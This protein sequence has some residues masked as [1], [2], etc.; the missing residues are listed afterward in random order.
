[1][2][3]RTR[4]AIAVVALL[5][6][7]GGHELR[8]RAKRRAEAAER[9]WLRTERDSY[10]TAAWDH[11][12]HHRREAAT[13]ALRA[14]ALDHQLREPPAADRLA[15][16]RAAYATRS[17]AEAAGA[18]ALVTVLAHVPGPLPAR[19]TSDGDFAIA[20]AHG[21]TTH[22]GKTGKLLHSFGGDTSSG[23]A[24]FQRERVLVARP[25]GDLVAWNANTEASIGEN[26]GLATSP[27]DVTFARDAPFAIA[28]RGG[29]CTVVDGDL[30]ERTKVVPPNGI[31]AT[32][33]APDG[34][35]VAIAGQDGGWTVF[36]VDAKKAVVTISSVASPPR[37]FLTNEAIVVALAET[38]VL[39]EVS[40]KKVAELPGTV[41][42]VSD[43]GAW[44]ATESRGQL[45]YFRTI[46]GGRRGGFELG[47]RQRT[48]LARDGRQVAVL[49]ETRPDLVVRETTGREIATFTGHA[50]P[51]TA[52]SW[53]GDGRYL[54]TASQDRTLRLW[55]VHADEHAVAEIEVDEVPDEIHL[56]RDATRIVTSGRVVRLYDVSIDG[57]IA[58]LCRAAEPEPAVEKVCR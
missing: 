8:A 35:H 20:G 43:D 30:R 49:D 29:D 46:T 32:L 13:M 5:A 15:I 3:R 37:A 24:S 14:V 6:V 11:A 34:K 23:V 18:P 58:S 12:L 22:D 28:C 44:L 40:G 4:V 39:H 45:Q 56:S 16:T 17:W 21:A 26:V 2:R 42:Q 9:A 33:I 51:I 48:A 25:G 38:S 1:M 47:P 41:V 7:I 36:D 27:D 19:F 10:A 53:N 52:V 57:A 50:A 31:V 54:A 55:A